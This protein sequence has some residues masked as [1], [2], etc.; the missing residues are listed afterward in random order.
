MLI[1]DLLNG[2][3]APKQIPAD[4]VLAPGGFYVMEMTNYL[5]NS[6]DDVR[7]LATDGS[8]VYDFKHYASGIG[9]DLSVCRQPNGG[10]WVNNCTASKGSANP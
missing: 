6:G 2:G 1:D 8:T 4:T 7:L 10:A 9:Y 3:G 5:N